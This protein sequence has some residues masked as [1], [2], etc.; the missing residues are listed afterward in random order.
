MIGTVLVCG[1]YNFVLKA[2]SRGNMG[3]EKSSS[4]YAIR[5]K[6]Q[7]REVESRCG[8]DMAIKDTFE[9]EG[10]GADLGESQSQW[11]LDPSYGE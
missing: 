10:Q 2:N 9:R 11:S 5:S 8:N 6:G 4:N 1:H 3:I 7:G